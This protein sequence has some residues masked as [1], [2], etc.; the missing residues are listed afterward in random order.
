MN[1]VIIVHCEHFV[2]SKVLFMNEG[3]S[4]IKYF[5]SLY[6]AVCNEI[7][8]YDFVTLWPIRIRFVDGLHDEHFSKSIIIF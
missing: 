4:L 8:N 5:M 3:E 7:Y 2:M 1:V 6:P